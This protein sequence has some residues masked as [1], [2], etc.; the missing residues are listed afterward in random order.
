M[1]KSVPGICFAP[2]GRDI[3][4]NFISSANLSL[5]SRHLLTAWVCGC[6]ELDVAIFFGLYCACFELKF[7]PKNEMPAH[8]FFLLDSNHRS[9]VC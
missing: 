1:N 3:H 8:I 9:S 2:L 5:F 6:S 4:L 7:K